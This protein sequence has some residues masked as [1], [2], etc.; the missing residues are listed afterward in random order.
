MKRKIALFTAVIMCAVLMLSALPVFA[1][2]SDEDP[3][4][5]ARFVAEGN[6]PYGTL[7]FSSAGKNSTIDPDT[8]T[9][10]AIRYRTEAQYDDT[11]VEYTGQFYISP[12]AEPCIPIKYEFTKKWETAVVDMTSVNESTSLDSKWDSS[13]YTSP[14][15]IRFDPLEPDRDSEDTSQDDVNGQVIAGDYIDIEWIAFFEKEEDARA[16]TGKED[17][18]YCLLD[19]ESFRGLSGTNKL[20]VSVVSGGEVEATP[21]PPGLDTYYYLYDGN[22]SVHTGWW[23]NPLLEDSRIDV[24]FTSETW[25]GG[26]TYFSYC[27]EIDTPMIL[28]LSDA[29]EN[30]LWTLETTN[31]S[32][33]PYTV[34]MGKSFMPGDYILSFIG[35]DVSEIETGLWFV[36]GSGGE[37]EDV[38]ATV[39]GGATN[40]DTLPK[41]YISLIKAEADPDYTVPPTKVPATPTPTKEPTEAPTAAPATAT[42]AAE[43]PN[44]EPSGETAKP[45]ATDDKNNS[46]SKEKKNNTG[47]IIGI[48]AAA[49]VIVAAVATIIAVSK[50]KKK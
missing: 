23:L 46:E 13:S 22:S 14:A 33:A 4:V 28:V 10:A 31:R 30:E 16:Y 9:W 38:E 34:D 41:P 29:D 2:E 44:D 49:A 24:E 43:D 37:N 11:G 6:D 48:I 35:G 42:S 39:S 26:F 17:T 25:F 8:V 21:E 7:R 15:T 47:L 32:N 19:M 1:A 40:G 50:K 5:F 20:S 3:A 27:N 45:G 36:L 18:P 12:A